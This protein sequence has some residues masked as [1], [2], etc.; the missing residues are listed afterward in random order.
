MSKF[1]PKRKKYQDIYLD[2]YFDIGY[3]HK[4]IISAEATAPN[5]Y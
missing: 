4:N 5:I 2:I 3:N 1:Y